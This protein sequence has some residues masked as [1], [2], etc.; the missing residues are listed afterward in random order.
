M[1]GILGMMHENGETVTVKHIVSKSQDK[2]YGYQEITDNIQQFQ[3]KAIIMPA[4]AKSG[5]EELAL[6]RE[7]ILTFGDFKAFFEPF[8][9]ID[10]D[11][12]VIW[13]DKRFR[14]FRIQ[15]YPRKRTQHFIKCFLRKLP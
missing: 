13:N 11:D 15:K 8:I 5:G 6:E 14:V 10:N 4:M 3:T 1:S 9:E 7:G 12:E 2:E